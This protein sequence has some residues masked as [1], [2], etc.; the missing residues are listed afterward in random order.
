MKSGYVNKIDTYKIGMASLELG[1]GRKTKE[2]KIDSMAGII[3]KIK[4]GQKINT[5]DEIA[6]LFSNE[7]SKIKIAEKM[8][9]ESISISKNKTSKPKLIKKILY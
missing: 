8:I 5:Y 9:L 7:K 4:I 2:D 6:V 3:F 1:A